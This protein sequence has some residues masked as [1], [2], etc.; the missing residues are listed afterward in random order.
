MQHEVEIRK[1]TLFSGDGFGR[2]SVSF[3]LGPVVVRGAKVFEKEGNRWL[4]MPGRKGGK[5]DW[6][7]WVY[8]EDRET[9][10]HLERLV[11]HEYERVMTAPPPEFEEA[12]A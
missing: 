8:I 5:G 11:L 6:V 10:D 12:R 7:D 9:R 4:S 2:A 1:V 3:R